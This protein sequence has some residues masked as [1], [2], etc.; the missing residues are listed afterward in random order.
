LTCAVATLGDD[1]AAAYHRPAAG[2][3]PRAALRRPPRGDAGSP[4]IT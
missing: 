2:R 4:A 3:V 1:G